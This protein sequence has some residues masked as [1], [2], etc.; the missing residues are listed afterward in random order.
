MK[1]KTSQDAA[2]VM[3]IYVQRRQDK[4]LLTAAGGWTQDRKQARAFDRSLDA[5]EAIEGYP[6]EIQLLFNFDEN[7]RYDFTIPGE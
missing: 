3:K 1:N 7:G 2:R 4:K 6:K 5:R